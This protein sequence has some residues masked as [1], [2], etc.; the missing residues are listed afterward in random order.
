LQTAVTL[1][2]FD[3]LTHTP[4]HKI[5]MRTCC[6]LLVLLTDRSTLMHYF[7]LFTKSICIAQLIG[8]SH[9]GPE[10]TCSN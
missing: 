2:R 10:A 3:I 7:T 8:M 6:E 1:N 9:C 4:T 5:L